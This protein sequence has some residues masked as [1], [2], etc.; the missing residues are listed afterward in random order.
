MNKKKYIINN[1]AI[2]SKN[3][4]KLL[5]LFKKEISKITSRDKTNRLFLESSKYIF[6][7]ENKC[8]I[9]IIKHFKLN[10]NVLITIDNQVFIKSILKKAF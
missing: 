7:F 6:L 4:K 2:I 3:D 9:D 8:K 5:F 10:E 1:F